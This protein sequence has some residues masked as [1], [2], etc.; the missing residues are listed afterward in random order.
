MAYAASSSPPIATRISLNN[1]DFLR[2]FVA[3]PVSLRLALH[4]SPPHLRRSHA[5]EPILPNRPRQLSV[6][7]SVIHPNED[8]PAE[9]TRLTLAPPWGMQT[10]LANDSARNPNHSCPSASDSTSDSAVNR[11]KA[12]K[13]CSRAGG[14]STE[15]IHIAGRINHSLRVLRSFRGQGLS[16]RSSACQREADLDP[17]HAESGG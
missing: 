13:V 1:S 12:T 5:P 16:A 17:L 8:K 9:S 3:R 15:L 4:A 6:T 10:Y 14:R 7:S 11:V 2:F